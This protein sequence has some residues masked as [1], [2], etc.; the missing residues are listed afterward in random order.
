MLTDRFFQR[1]PFS[2]F[3]L[4]ILVK[5]G[6]GETLVMEKEERGKQC[7]FSLTSHQDGVVLLLVASI[8]LS[9]T[10]SHQPSNQE[11]SSLFELRP[12][13]PSSNSWQ[14]WKEDTYKYMYRYIYMIY[15]PMSLC[16]KEENKRWLYE[17]VQYEISYPPFILFSLK[18][19][20]DCLAS[21]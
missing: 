11:H 1:Y 19:W 9:C 21:V 8:F 20:Y 15:T 12:P 14:I 5:N 2:L 4:F 6:I 18:Y 10:H 3:F 16:S 7:L 13:E 17:R